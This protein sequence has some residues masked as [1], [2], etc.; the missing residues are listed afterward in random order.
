MWDGLII[1]RL[2]HCCADEFILYIGLVVFIIYVGEL[3]C[4]LG[5]RDVWSVVTDVTEWELSSVGVTSCNWQFSPLFNI[6]HQCLSACCTTRRR[7]L[8]F[9]RCSLSTWLTQR[10]CSKFL[11]PLQQDIFVEHSY[12]NKCITLMV[13][14]ISTHLSSKCTLVRNVSVQILRLQIITKPVDQ[15]P[16]MDSLQSTHIGCQPPVDR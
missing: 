15:S 4:S 12:S 13:E 14:T 5:R 6:L 7:P 16:Q 1:C 10:F 2:G 8:S 11:I 3:C 9:Q